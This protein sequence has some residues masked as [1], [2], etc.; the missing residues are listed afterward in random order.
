M[1]KSYDELQFTDDFMFR[2][3]PSGFSELQE[4]YR[5]RREYYID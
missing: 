5:Y 2:T 4:N 3:N 1:S